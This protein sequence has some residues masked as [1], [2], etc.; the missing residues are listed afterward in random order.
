MGEEL[1]FYISYSHNN[2]LFYDIRKYFEFEYESSYFCVT[3]FN[4]D[5]NDG[6]IITFY[7]NVNLNKLLINNKHNAVKNLDDNTIKYKKIIRHDS[8]F[9]ISSRIINKIIF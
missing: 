7:F 9:I 6:T 1:A 2:N 8:L 5:H 3:F 4:K